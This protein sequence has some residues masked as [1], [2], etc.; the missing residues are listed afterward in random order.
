MIKRL[1]LHN[2]SIFFVLVFGFM[3]NAQEVI[4]VNYLSRIKNADKISREDL[5]QNAVES[6]SNEN[7]RLLIGAAKADRNQKVINEKVIK[8]SSRYILSMKN[9][10]IEKK[11]ADTVMPVEFKVS[12]KNLRAILLE[13]GLLY[14]LEG[15]PKVLSLVS[16]E[17]RV[18]SRQYAWWTES[19]AKDIKD[20]SDMSASFEKLMKDELAKI[21]FVGL[22]PQASAPTGSPANLLVP[23]GLRISALQKTD[24]LSLGEKLKA[25]MVV[26]GEV[27]VRLKP[28]S[29]TIFLLEYNV[30]AFHSANGRLIAEV[31]RSF[32]TD[33]GAYRVVAPRTFAATADKVVADLVG[34]VNEVWK[35]GVFGASALRLTVTGGLNPQNMD[36]LK[37]MIPL[38]VRDVKNLRERRIEARVTTYEIDSTGVPQQLAAAFKSANFSPFKVSVKEVGSDGLT[39]DVQA[40]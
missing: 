35:K 7:I 19:A 12:L 27:A 16:I 14:Q 3:A 11:G 36:Q 2:I 37:R 13:E 30:Q 24:S 20:L 21:S 6:V 18:A 5:V 29:E 38:Q 26:R 33:A 17:D 28:N 22:T 23:Q 9:G 15:S 10:G 32:E 8:N 4:D 39:L 34:Q 31:Q 1:M 25:Q 40:Q